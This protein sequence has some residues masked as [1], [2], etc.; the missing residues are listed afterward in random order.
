MS[1]GV[2]AQAHRHRDLPGDRRQGDRTAGEEGQ[3]SGEILAPFYKAMPST[4]YGGSSEIQR[5]I[6]AK[7]VLNL[8]S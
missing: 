6:L 5:N 8:P 4:I 2:H 1:F 7:S 3:L